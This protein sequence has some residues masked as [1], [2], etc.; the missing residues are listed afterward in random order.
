M[1]GI[2]RTC[3]TCKYWKYPLDGWNDPVRVSWYLDWSDNQEEKAQ[4]A[5]SSRY[6]ECT[7]VAE[8]PEDWKP[9]DPIPMAVVRDGSSYQATLYTRDDFGCVQWEE[10]A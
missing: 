1:S 7:E 4:A 8:N 2:D 3:A 9:G 5:L 10:T 6:G